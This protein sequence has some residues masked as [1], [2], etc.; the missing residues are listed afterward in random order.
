L[1]HWE[2]E[3][4]KKWV[5]ISFCSLRAFMLFLVT[6][7]YH[8]HLSGLESYSLPRVCHIGPNWVNNICVF[9]LFLYLLIF[10]VWNMSVVLLYTVWGYFNHWLLLSLLHTYLFHW[11]DFLRIHNRFDFNEELTKKVPWKKEYQMVMMHYLITWTYV[12]QY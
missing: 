8:F 3:W 10:V 11:C 6:P 7:L 1:I 9:V 4:L 12:I 2:C 5:E